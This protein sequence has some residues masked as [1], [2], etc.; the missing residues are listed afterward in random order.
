MKPTILS[1]LLTA[2]LLTGCATRERLDSIQSKAEKLLEPG[3]ESAAMS[4]V[5]TVPGLL[6]R[7]EARDA[8]LAHAGLTIGQVSRLQV[9]Y[10][11]ENGI[12]RYE[13]EFHQ[14]QWEYHYEIDARTGE[15]LT[16]ER[17]D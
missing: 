4:T 16:F 9:E 15:V 17:D 13:V 2:L 11:P 7:E 6:T 14:G 5:E 3:L 10:D 8:A 12:P 1:F